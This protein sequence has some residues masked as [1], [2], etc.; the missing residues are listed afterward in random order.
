MDLKHDL[1]IRLDSTISHLTSVAILQANSSDKDGIKLHF[2]E[3]NYQQ[4]GYQIYFMVIETAHKLTLLQFLSNSY[5][6][7][8]RLLF[9]HLNLG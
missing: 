8:I 1:E 7:D 6:L 2:S 5:L 9:A 3:P 4:L